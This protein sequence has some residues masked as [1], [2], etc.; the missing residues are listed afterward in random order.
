MKDWKRRRGNIKKMKRLKRQVMEEEYWDKERRKVFQTGNGNQTLAWIWWGGHGLVRFGRVLTKLYTRILPI[1]R[2]KITIP[3]GFRVWRRGGG[4]GFLIYLGFFFFFVLKWR[5]AHPP[6]TTLVRLIFCKAL[7]LALACRG[8][9]YTAQPI[10]RWNSK[11]IKTDNVRWCGDVCWWCV[12]YKQTCQTTKQT[13]F[14][15][16][17]GSRERDEREIQ[18]AKSS[19]PIPI[20]IHGSNNI[21]AIL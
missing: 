2:L 7:T 14:Y 3:A 8:K 1:I 9:V 12:S 5:P 10:H 13:F 21:L 4:C 15:R 19:I 6:L 18:K 17:R 16:A 11:E 20:P